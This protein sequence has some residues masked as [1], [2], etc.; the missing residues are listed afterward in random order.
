MDVV[1]RESILEHAARAFARLGFKK[2]SIDLIA[3]AA[4]VAKGTIYLACESKADLFYQ[5]VHRELRAWLAETSRTIDPR[6][7]AGELLRATSAASI[8]F[9]EARPLVRDLF[10]GLH[11]GQIPAWAERFEELRDVGQQAIAEI[12]RLGQRQGR[13]RADLDVTLVAGA[14]QDMHIAGYM[15]MCQAGAVSQEELQQRFD[16]TFDV[17]LNGLRKR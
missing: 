14:L 6:E 13:F 17:V 2:T 16:A 4:G 9:L 3:Q 11:A 10:F 7:P 5:S 15:F 12:I 1:K 8:A